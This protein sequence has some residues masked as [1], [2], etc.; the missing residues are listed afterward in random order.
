[1]LKVYLSSTNVDL[2]DYR[3]AVTEILRAPLEFSVVDSYDAA[4]GTVRESCLQ[5]VATCQV[6]V[7][8]IAWRYG[9]IPE[10]NN[11]E[12]KSITELEYLRA[13]EVPGMARFLFLL[14]AAEP[15]PGDKDH[16]DIKNGSEDAAT[17][18]KSLR[19]RVVVDRATLFKAQPADLAGKVLRALER[20]KAEQLEKEKQRHLTLAEAPVMAP[21][22]QRP[23]P[24]HL[25]CAGLLVHVS[26]TDN[27]SAQRIVSVLERDYAIQ[28]F[29]FSP[30]DPPN[31]A[32]LD[33]AL[34]PCRTGLLLVTPASLARMKPRADMVAALTALIRE[35]TGGCAV[36]RAGVT[37]AELPR[38]WSPV[39]TFDLGDWLAGGTA[40]IGGQLTDFINDVR[41]WNPDFDH[42]GLIGLQYAVIAMTAAEAKQLAANPQAVK[43]KLLEA[44]YNYFL[45]MTARL[46]EK[47]IAWAERY[48]ATRGAWRPF[49]GKTI[50]EFLHA[51]VSDINDQARENVSPR[52]QQNLRGHKIRLRP[53]QFQP[54][55]G[56]DD[57]RGKLYE[58]MKR[59]GCL[60]LVDELSMFEPT[61]RKAANAFLSDR[62]VSVATLSPLDPMSF[63]LDQAV[64]DDGPLNVGKLLTRFRVALDP[65]CE[66]AI[67]SQA[68]LKRWLRQS[69]P[70]TLGF[71][72]NQGALPDRRADIVKLAFGS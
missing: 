50:E 51:A 44:D 20:W 6:Y 59:R 46:T 10:D 21:E 53:Y 22:R 40:A 1:M 56:D 24:R 58:Q 17:K 55:T 68:R 66:L 28:R 64:S 60:V 63:P 27:T 69:V 3:E 18:I 32:A 8:I 57:E 37:A 16:D 65:Q 54:L 34:A 67:A 72:E 5:D 48:G 61:L 19:E 47:N 62:E 33:S 4:T 38:Q 70:E 11:R 12:R 35:R 9:H 2:K 36:I 45:D 7:G 23:H 39:Q 15:W 26:G 71:L 52:D 14:D 29:A 42:R 43:P 31:L 13:K 30:D 41:S 25:G 49:G